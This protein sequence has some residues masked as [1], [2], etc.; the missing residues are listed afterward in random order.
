MKIG[1][2]ALFFQFQATGSGQYLSHL[3]NALAEIDH[4]NQYI[5]L[6]PQPIASLPVTAYPYQTH[7]VPRLLSKSDNLE[8][9][10]WEQFTGPRAA[11][12]Q[13]VDLLHIPYFAP[14]LFPRTPTVV[15]IHDVLSFR[16]QPISPTAK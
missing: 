2:N 16:L 13:Q 3:L 11:K 12:R 7:P 15:T 14:P 4:H 6:G 1:V 9:V 5:L 10:I 8:K